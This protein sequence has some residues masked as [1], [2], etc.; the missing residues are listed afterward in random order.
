MCANQEIYNQ[1][2][3]NTPPAYQNFLCGGNQVSANETYFIN[4]YARTMILD[5]GCGTGNRTFPIWM[6][7]GIDFIGI[8]KYQNL[9]EASHLPE[10][11]LQADLSDSSFPDLVKPKLDSLE[12]KPEIAFLL[13]GVIDGILCKENQQMAWANFDFLLQ[14]CEYILIDTLTNFEWYEDDED[15]RMVILGNPFPPQYFYSSKEIGK[16]NQTN[17]ITIA[18]TISEDIFGKIR[19]HFLLKKS[20]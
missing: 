14:Y 15:G 9:I 19:T 17:N 2:I 18:E 4:N 13:G 7:R 1:W 16:L 20:N 10:K 12:K 5:I 8:E 11:Y 3:R 6:N